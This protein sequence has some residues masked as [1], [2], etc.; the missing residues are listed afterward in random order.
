MVQCHTC[1][2]V[3]SKHYSFMIAPLKPAPT[4]GMVG[5]GYITRTEDGLGA[6]LPDP[7]LGSTGSHIQ[8]LLTLLKT[9]VF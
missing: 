8:P 9:H 3:S 7:V 4:L 5:R 1:P 6:C 2:D